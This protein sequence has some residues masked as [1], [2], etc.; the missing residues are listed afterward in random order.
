MI[1]SNLRCNERRSRLEF[2]YGSIPAAELTTLDEGRVFMDMLAD[3]IKED[4]AKLFGP[5][6]HDR[7]F[8]E[9]KLAGVEA[10]RRRFKSTVYDTTDF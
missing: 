3:V 2:R 5:F 10:C 6:N 7:V 1:N 4:L 9:G 8:M